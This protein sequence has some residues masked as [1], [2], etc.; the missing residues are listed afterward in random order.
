MGSVA[1]PLTLAVGEMIGNDWAVTGCFMYPEDAPARLLRLVSSGA[2]DL[3]RCRVQR[4]SLDAL[5][6]A[7]RPRRR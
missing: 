5:D 6:A 4:F 7:M 1:E 3:G 2:L